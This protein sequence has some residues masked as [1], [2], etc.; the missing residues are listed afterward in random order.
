MMAKIMIL[1]AII[2]RLLSSDNSDRV[3]LPI[4]R[5]NSDSRVFSR[6]DLNCSFKYWFLFELFLIKSRASSSKFDD[7][8]ADDVAGEG[9]RLGEGDLDLGDIGIDT[10]SFLVDWDIV[11]KF[12]RFGEV[13]RALGWGLRSNLVDLQ[14]ENQCNQSF[15]LIKH[16]TFAWRQT[17]F[18]EEFEHAH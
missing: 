17:L 8:D 9:D 11:D 4:V 15:R 12:I 3:V 10:I 16:R 1:I 7:C 6:H 5:Q 18:E 13:G 2:R 14:L